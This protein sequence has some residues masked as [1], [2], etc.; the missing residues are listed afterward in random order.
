MTTYWIWSSRRSH[1]THLNRN[2]TIIC[3]YISTQEHH[4][5]MFR[6]IRVLKTCG[7]FSSS[8]QKHAYDLPLQ[9]KF[10]WIPPCLMKSVWTPNVT[11]KHTRERCSSSSSCYS[12]SNNGSISVSVSLLCVC[13]YFGLRGNSEINEGNSAKQGGKTF[14]D[15]ENLAGAW[16]AQLEQFPLIKGEGASSANPPGTGWKFIHLPPHRRGSINTSLSHQS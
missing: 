10:I 3:N 14:E 9:T 11:D 8:E 5:R 6:L 15:K 13:V 12:Y 1:G 2:D 7:A 16:M 4:T